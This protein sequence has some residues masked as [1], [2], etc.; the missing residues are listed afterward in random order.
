MINIKDSDVKIQTEILNP[1]IFQIG[2]LI[3]F[4]K[5]IPSLAEETN[6]TITLYAIIAGITDERIYTYVPSREDERGLEYKEIGIE[7][8]NDITNIKILNRDEEIVSEPNDNE[9]GNENESEIIGE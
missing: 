3:Q 8:F 4:D 1:E 9:S 7:E 5:G 2:D 6:E